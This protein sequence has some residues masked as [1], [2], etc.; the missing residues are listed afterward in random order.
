MW[1]EVNGEMVN[2][3]VLKNVDDKDKL[4]PLPYAEK[5][6]GYITIEPQ[7]GNDTPTVQKIVAN[8]SY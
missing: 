1:A 7:G 2:L 5:A 3:G 4:W 8:I 6:V